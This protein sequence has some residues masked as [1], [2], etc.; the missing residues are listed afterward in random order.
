M[1]RDRV[2]RADVVERKTRCAGFAHPFARAAEIFA[3]DE[4]RA[5]EP[6]IREQAG[7][8]RRGRCIPRQGENARAVMQVRDDLFQRTAVQRDRRAILLAPAEMRSSEAESG[9]R[10]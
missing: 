2:E 1:Q 4:A 10:R 7:E 9:G 6:A 8:F 5:A 3:E